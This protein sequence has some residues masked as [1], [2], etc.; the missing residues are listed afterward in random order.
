[1][2]L[3]WWLACGEGD[4]PADDGWLAPGEVARAASMRYPKRR[5]EYVLRRLVAK[6]AIAALSGCHPN[7]S[8]LASIEVHNDP[9][10]APHAHVDAVP[11]ALDLSITDRAGWAV[12]VVG[13]SVGC[14]LELIEPRSA[15]F[16]RDYLT[17]AERAFVGAE[18]AIGRAAAANLIWSAKES[19]LKVLRTGLRRDT[20]SVEVSIGRAGD[21]GWGRLTVRAVEGD[22]F[23]GWWRRDGPFVLTVAARSPGPAPIALGDPR[24]LASAVARPSRPDGPLPH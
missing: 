24:V 9:T 5:A 18:P 11:F 1:M 8:T 16:I 7:P 2:P 14:D 6:R 22:V 15:G 3:T 13:T 12:C 10:G 4:L 17:P 23:P 20:R 19:A 21:G